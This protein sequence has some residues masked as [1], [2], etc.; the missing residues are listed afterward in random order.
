MASHISPTAYALL[1]AAYAYPPIHVRLCMC[2][3]GSGRM[4]MGMTLLYEYMTLVC[5]LLYDRT[6]VTSA[7]SSGTSLRKLLLTD[8]SAAC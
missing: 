3:Y 2:A 4:G 6:S 7:I 5:G 1:P 8:L